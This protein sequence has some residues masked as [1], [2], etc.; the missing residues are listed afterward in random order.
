MMDLEEQIAT[1]EPL[2]QQA[3]E[4]MPIQRG[5]RSRFA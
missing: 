3:M 4:A 5:Q 1:G 2:M